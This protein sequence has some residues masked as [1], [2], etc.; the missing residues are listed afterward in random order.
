MN[1][2]V[3]SVF[4]ILCGVLDFDVL[5]PLKLFVPCHKTGNFIILNYMKT[6]ITYHTLTLP[7]FFSFSDGWLDQELLLQVS[8]LELGEF[9]I[10][11]CL[12]LKTL[13]LL[14]ICGDYGE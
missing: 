2:A 5:S 13:I 4:S 11:F 3:V 7:H 10:N 1:F 6:K 12:E 9:K 14:P 8:V